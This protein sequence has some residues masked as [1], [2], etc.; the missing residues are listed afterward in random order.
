MTEKEPMNTHP[1]LAPELSLRNS[2]GNIVSSVR[3]PPRVSL[4]RDS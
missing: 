4:E 1:M 2:R 3:S